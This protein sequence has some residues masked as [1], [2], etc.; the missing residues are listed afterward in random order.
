MKDTLHDA[1]LEYHRLPT[2]G[3]ISITPTTPLATQR[4]LALAYSPG[5]AVPCLEIEKDPLKALDYTS[6]GNLV[7]VISNGTAVLGLGDIG[8]LASKPVMEGKAVLFKKFANIDAIDIEV[9]EKDPDKLVE[10]IAALEPS[11]GGINL[12]DIK[13]PECF[14]VEKRLKE[15]MNIPVFHDDQHGTA[16]IVTAAIK[17]WLHLKDRK[18]EDIRLVANGAGAAALACLNLLVNAGLP[19][20]NII[21]CDRKGVVYKGRAEQMDPY[22]EQFASDTNSRTLDEALEGADIF[23]GLS[24]AGALT[25]EMVKKM[26]K[27]PLIMALAN[28]TPEIMPEE[29]REAKPDAII[30]TGRSDYTNQVNNVLC[31]PFL[32][33]GALD[34]GATAINEEMKLACVNAIAELARKEVTA[35]VAAVY[36][37]EHLE[38]GPEYLIPKPFDPRLITTLPVAVAKAAIESGVAAR[39]ITDWAAYSEKLNSYTY[40]TSMAMRPLFSRAKAHPKRIVY[41]EGEEE[42]VLRAVQTVVD[43]HLASPI[44]IGRKDVVET[45]LKRLGLRMKMGKDFELIDPEYDPRYRDYWSSYHQIMERRGVTP[46]VA[47]TVLRTNFTVIGA[48]MV[49]KGEADAMICGTV[50]QYQSHLKDV[51][52]IIGLRPG[53]ETAAALNALILP[54]GTF[55]ICDTQVNPNPSVAQLSEMTILAA[56]EV[57]RFGIKPKI[58]MLSHSNFGTGNSDTACRMRAALA[59]IR[60]RAPE[61]EIDG[62]M[63]ADSALSEAIRAVS[64]PNSTLSG[65]ANM[66]VMPNIDSANISFNML[67]ILGEGISIGPILLG[68]A[69]P[70]HILTPSVTPR[71]I[72]NM[73]ALATVSAQVYETECSTDAPKKAAAV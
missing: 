11:F 31:F 48:L 41:A 26:G 46:A 68:L 64:M 40:R 62:E 63:H 24:A 32:F 21:V 65:V 33:R 44:L 22:K 1:A 66:F 52:D 49:R 5:V 56:E 35:E 28:P 9:D 53:V 14:E 29:A 51:V 25:G 61:L 12:E 34:V 10:I 57:S 47:R 20:K 7:A 30:C 71:G 13:A 55:F 18:F 19:K 15:R 67:R 38:F 16:I 50:G 6:R 3:K 17:N 54:R 72:I 42:R 8:A 58:A 4:D 36:P 27:A 69:M 70:A 43:E 39:P 37:D 60:N 45:R 73:T 23:L 59:D 2:P